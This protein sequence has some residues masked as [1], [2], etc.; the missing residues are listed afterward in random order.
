LVALAATAR[1]AQVPIEKG[2]RF[3]TGEGPEPVN[4][5]SQLIAYHLVSGPA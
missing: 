4:A 1:G 3:D 2:Y 5:R